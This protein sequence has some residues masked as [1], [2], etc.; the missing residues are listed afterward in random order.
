MTIDQPFDIL[1]GLLKKWSIKNVISIDDGWKIENADIDEDFLFK[2]LLQNNYEISQI[3]TSSMFENFSEISNIIETVD[4]EEFID[5]YQ[6]LSQFDMEKLNSILLGFKPRELQFNAIEESLTFLSRVL[7]QLLDCGFNVTNASEYN[8]S[9]LE[10]LE[11]K[12]LWLLDREIKGD[13]SQVFSILEKVVENKDVALIITN[14]DSTLSS[15]GQIREFVRENFSKYHTLAT[16]FLW[17]LRKDKVDSD[18]MISIKNVLQGVTLN[19][20]LNIYNEINQKIE[21]IADERLRFL[22]PEDINDFFRSSFSEGSQLSDTLL[23][24]RRAVMSKSFNEI[25]SNESHYV[26]SLLNNRE[27]I[28][29]I[30]LPWGHEPTEQSAF[31]AAGNANSIG[32][33]TQD[34]KVIPIHSYEQWD[35]NVNL[36]GSCVYTGDLFVKTNYNHKSNQ[37]VKSKSVYLLITQPCDTVLRNTNGTIQ[38]GSKV[39]NLIKGELIEYGT[40]SYRRNVEQQVPNKLKVH[41]ARINDKYGMILFDLKNMFQIDFKILDLCSLDPNGEALL[42]IENLSRSRFMTSISKKYYDQDMR[43]FIHSLNNYQNETIETQFRKFSK[44]KI[45]VEE[46]KVILEKEFQKTT[47]KNDTIIPPEIDFIS[48]CGFTISRVARL[49]DEYILNII[50]QSTEYQGRQALPGLML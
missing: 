25:I 34:H 6:T 7:Q 29:Q 46:L 35:Y 10:K 37:W 28:E 45:T 14:D 9:L 24:I 16:S 3:C 42:S 47:L 20:T 19:D 49:N 36:L 41:F 23:R 15:R 38:R 17:V 26:D 8:V 18:L 32:D 13:N 1:V 12:T 33:L 50:K 27:L 11:G 21:N 48:E 30:L 40:S 44:D 31:V 2:L 22:E 43:D 4:F 39:A 5:L